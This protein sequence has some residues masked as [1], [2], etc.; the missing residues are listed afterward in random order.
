MRRI[1]DVALGVSSY[2][3]TVPTGNNVGTNKC[4]NTSPNDASN[5]APKPFADTG[6]GPDGAS[7]VHSLED[8][9]HKDSI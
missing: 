3:A 5:D 1:N 9:Y 7:Y 6:T 2:Y 8:S 4:T